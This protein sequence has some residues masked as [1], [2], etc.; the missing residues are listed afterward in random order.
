MYASSREARWAD[1]SENGTEFCESKLTTRSD[2]KPET[3]TTSG[4]VAV[5]SAPAWARTVMASARAGVRTVT[6]SAEAAA[7]S[8]ATLASAMT[9]PRPTTTR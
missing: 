9:V 1:S 6:R 7:I 4:A 3:V 2:E 8:S 5:T